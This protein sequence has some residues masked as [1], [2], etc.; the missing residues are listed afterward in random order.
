[1]KKIILTLVAIIALASC[2]KDD[3][4]PPSLIGKWE[5]QKWNR[6]TNGNL[7]PDEQPFFSQPDCRKVFFELKTN[8]IATLT[9][10]SGATCEV[11]SRDEF[12]LK[13][14]Q[15]FQANFILPDMNG[16]IV[17]LTNSELIF[18]ISNSRFI[19]NTTTD[20]RLYRITCSRLP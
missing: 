16:K 18:D 20:M 14:D 13:D 10:S 8:N 7:G 6:F 3:E 12:Y 15:I 5:I 11:F 2:A 9:T 4:V 1:M 17:S 19:L